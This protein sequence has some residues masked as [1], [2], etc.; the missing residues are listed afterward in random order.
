VIDDISDSRF[1]S[2]SASPKLIFGLKKNP[3]F[4]PKVNF[5]EAEILKNRDLSVVDHL[6][7][8]VKMSFQSN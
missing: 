6:T 5:G 2:I 7:L 4:S 8:P 3:D 1:F